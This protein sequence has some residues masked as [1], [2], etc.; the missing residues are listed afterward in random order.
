MAM[1]I[2]EDKIERTVRIAAK[3]VQD[4]SWFAEHS[5][6]L[7]QTQPGDIVLGMYGTVV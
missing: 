2:G 4:Q 3:P 1:Y 5:K 6:G 7:I